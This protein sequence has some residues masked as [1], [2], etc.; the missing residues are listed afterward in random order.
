M[1]FVIPDINGIT[2]TIVKKSD[3]AQKREHP[4][5]SITSL[6]DELIFL[7]EKLHYSLENETKMPRNE[8][9][10]L[11][12]ECSRNHN[13]LSP[14]RTPRLTPD[15]SLEPYKAQILEAIN[16]DD[17]IGAATYREQVGVLCNKLRDSTKD[18]KIPYRVIGKLFGVSGSAV[19]DEQNKFNKGTK[20]NGRPTLL[21][22]EETAKLDDII[23]DLI[24]SDGYPTI[25]DIQ[26]SIYEN[27]NKVVTTP[28]IRTTLNKSKTYKITHASPMEQ[29]R[30]ECSDEAI[31]E[32]YDVLKQKVNGIPVGWCYNID[33]TGEQDFVDA[34]EISVVVPFETDIKDLKYPV[35]RNG[36]RSTLIHCICSDGSFLRPLFVLPRK[37][38][39]SEVFDVITP[40][41]AMFESTP[42]GFVNTEIFCK[43]MDGEFLPSIQMK[44]EKTGYTGKAILILDG[45]SAHYKCIDDPTRKANIEK[46]NIDVVFIPPHS[47]NQVQPLDLLTFALQKKWKREIKISKN[48]SYQ[49]QQI[50][51][52]Y[53]SVVRA[54]S[55]RYIV[56]AF[57][58]AGI[59]RLGMKLINGTLVHTHYAAIELADVYQNLKKKKNP[60]T[61]DPEKFMENKNENKKISLSEFAA[62]LN[63]YKEL[64]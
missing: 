47:S 4:I 61:P 5:Q 39:D 56:A 29:A 53:E 58:R 27:F 50:I 21:S 37:T 18:E 25:I 59:F 24:K 9:N 52:T 16:S 55:P 40:G 43:W 41:S 64:K 6:V 60:S 19:H 28:T 11:L 8:R 33:E 30:Y 32:Y 7:K 2:K 12:A 14:P 17:F 20:K 38:L 42:T 23:A 44:R 34:Q 26:D 49:S 63:Q 54:S 3:D 48:F 13:S 15:S 57:K 1:A 22:E 62:I 35:S 46:L 31:K 36:K 10:A 45:F 51:K